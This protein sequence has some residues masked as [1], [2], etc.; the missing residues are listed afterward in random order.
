MKSVDEES[1][2]RKT[3]LEKT[4]NINTIN[5]EKKHEA[6]D[7]VKNDNGSQNEGDLISFITLFS[8]SLIFKYTYAYIYMGQQPTSFILD[9]Y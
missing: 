4:N 3:L 9:D 8:I 5:N 2:E 7:N 6:Q 1:L